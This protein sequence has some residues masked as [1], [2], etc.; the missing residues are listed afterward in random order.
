[1]IKYSKYFKDLGIKRKYIP[2]G[3]NRNDDR[4]PEW[5]KE[6]RVYGLDERE[7]WGLDY[8]TALFLYSRLM[9]FKECSWAIVLSNNY[10]VEKYDLMYSQCINLVLDNLEIHLNQNIDDTDKNNCLKT[11]IEIYG[12]IIYGLWW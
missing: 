12:E 10:Y 6:R 4:H 8:T 3:W 9:Y 7:T 5:R 11:A 2:D 1:M